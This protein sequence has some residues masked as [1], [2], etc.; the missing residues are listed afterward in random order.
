MLELRSVGVYERLREASE[1]I[2]SVLDVG[3]AA[4]IR[5]SVVQTVSLLTP[6]GPVTVKPPRLGECRRRVR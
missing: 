1:R 5:D 2:I 6:R 3:G 4:E